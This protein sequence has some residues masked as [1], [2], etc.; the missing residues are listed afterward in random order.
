MLK[1][2]VKLILKPLFWESTEEDKVF[3]KSTLI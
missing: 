2:R 1:T 3:Y